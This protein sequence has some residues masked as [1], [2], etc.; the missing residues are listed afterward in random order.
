MAYVYQHYPLAMY[1]NG[2]YTAVK[3]A[4]EEAVM[5]ADGWT[6]WNSDQAAMR[7]EVKAE[8]GRFEAHAD[9]GGVVRDDFQFVGGSTYDREGMVPAMRGEAAPAPYSIPALPGEGPDT[10]LVA[11]VGVFNEIL[12]DRDALTP[13]TSRDSAGDGAPP[14]KR[15]YTR[16]AK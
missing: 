2:A 10:P 16:K 3:N 13:A 12:Y 14:A 4:Q 1:R 9:A 6:D 15:K 7:G 8:I 11:S 5:V